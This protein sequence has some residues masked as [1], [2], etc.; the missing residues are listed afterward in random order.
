MQIHTPGPVFFPDSE[1]ALCR[2]GLATRGTSRLDEADVLFALDQGIN[3]LNW[4]PIPNGLSKAVSGLGRRREDVAVCVQFE[5]RTAK[6]AESELAEILREL[7]TEYVDVLTFYYVESNSQWDEI[8]GPGGS[9]DYCRRACEQGKVRLLGL[10]SHQ[11]PLAASIARTGLLDLLMVRYNAAHRGAETDVFPVTQD[12]NMPVIAF[13]CLRWGALLE[14]TPE[15]PPGFRV[16]RAPDWYRFVLRHPAVTVALTAPHDREELEEN[17]QV[18]TGGELSEAEYREV[19]EH[20][21]RVREHAAYF[22]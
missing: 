12:L 7:N 3:F 11:R 6:D 1:R 2:L 22:P 9:L 10:T 5:A 21:R 17:L 16:P 20:G 4:H 14:R 18:L 13:T 8:T 15:D 19:A